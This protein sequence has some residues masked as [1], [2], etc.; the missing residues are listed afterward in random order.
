MGQASYAATYT[1]ASFCR[2]C[3]TKETPLLTRKLVKS[4][5]NSKQRME[6]FVKHTDGQCPTQMSSFL[7]QK[8]MRIVGRAV[9][10][11]RLC[12]GRAAWGREWLGLFE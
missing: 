12:R 6:S 4:A 8:I 7:L 11:L 5:Q 9:L 2:S 1:K 10:N 3:H